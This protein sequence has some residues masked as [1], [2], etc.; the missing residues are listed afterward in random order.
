MVLKQTLTR[1][2]AFV[3]KTNQH[4]QNFRPDNPEINFLPVFVDQ[5][6]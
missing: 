5:S 4:A 2:C 6:G 3:A 1:K